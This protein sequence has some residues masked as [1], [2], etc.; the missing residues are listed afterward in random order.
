MPWRPYVVSNKLGRRQ[1]MRG[2]RLYDTKEEAIAS[3]KR[4]NENWMKLNY[5]KKYS[6]SSNFEYG[7]VDV[8]KRKYKYKVGSEGNKAL[9]KDHDSAKKTGNV[10]FNFKY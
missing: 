10:G 2:T 9:L 6:K 5:D 8:G 3:M 1:A 4:K 7:A